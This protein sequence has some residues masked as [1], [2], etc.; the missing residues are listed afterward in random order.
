MSKKK[1]RPK[2]KTLEFFKS[3]LKKG[4]SLGFASFY[5]CLALVAI[6][7]LVFG[8][9]LQHDFVDFDDNVYVY[10]NP[11]IT[12]GLSVDGV[13]T[14][15]THPHARNW[16][17]LTT[18]SH[19]LD[20]QL[21]G[22]K[23]RGHHFTNVLL[24]TIAVLL[25]FFVLKQMTDAFWPSAFVAAVFAIHPL[26]V[27]SVAWVSE[28][29]DVLIAFFF[30]L[31][32]GAY[33]RYAHKRSVG[34]YLAVALCLALGL[35]SKPMLVTVPFVLLLLDYWPL[36]RF[37]EK[38]TRL[39]LEKI[40]LLALSAP[41][42]IATLLAQHY[43]KGS[44]DQLP[45][46]WRLNN[47]AVSYVA[48]IWQMLWPV[49]LAPFYPHPNNQLPLWQ[50]LLAG[51]FLIAMSVL[52]IHWRKERPY[53][54]TGWFCYL[55]MLVPVIG[56]VQVGEQ[57]RADRY[58]YLP[59]VGLYVLIVWGVTDL[60]APPMRNSGSRFAATSL[61]PITH[62]SRRVEPGNPHGPGYKP[63]C[64]AIAT[65]IIVALS[66]C[67]FVQTSYWENSQVLWN[68]T[69]AV[70]PD[71]D[72]AHTS[73]GYLFLRRG[74]L[75]QAISHFEKALEIRSSH[76]LAQYDLGGALI[77][78]NLATALVRKGL[79]QEAI[80]H[81][82]KAAKMR[83]DYGD[84]YL[85]LG[86]IL[87]QQGRTDEAIALWRKAAST[88]LEDG[89]FHTVLGDAFLNKGLRRDAIAEY[90]LAA[91]SSPQDPL[92]RNNLAWLLATC[93]D[94]SIR[95]GAKATELASRAVQLSRGADPSCLRTLAAANAESGQFSEAIKVAQRGKEIATS[96]GN[97]QL[98]NVLQGDIAL[99]QIGLPVRQTFPEK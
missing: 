71:N 96:Q 72:M 91:R 10:Q 81:F 48:Y 58:T 14:A 34:R 50:I 39:V 23:A 79:L 29:K 69:L 57:A 59:E 38:R 54:L 6:T 46:T 86:S 73:L 4:P 55:G 75:D 62:G 66:W 15:F 63:F 31:T 74:E 18:I 3:P 89:S 65:A 49:Q 22:L 94:T 1:N 52:A 11:V 43:A 78:N 51:A 88:Q 80:D 77:E 45:F 32:L 61:R 17:P 87:F 40:P 2:K 8:Q 98:A 16:H 85:N 92:P 19:M 99:Y 95:D 41:S 28:R 36:K 56:L 25:L 68:H 82:E 9:T 64:A 42:C 13:L 83:P 90:E 21:F 33:V 7:W 5:A 84:V 37:S 76:A 12:R 60:I 35:M 97:L 53:I 70:S 27:E 47:A 20:C 24:H 44:M 26:H 30:L 93:G 67:A